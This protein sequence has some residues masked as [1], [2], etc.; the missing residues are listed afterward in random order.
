MD[1]ALE[2]DYSCRRHRDG[3]I[4]DQGGGLCARVGW[5]FDREGGKSLDEERVVRHGSTQE[6]EEG[7]HRVK[8]LA[9]QL[10]DSCGTV[11]VPH[12]W[13]RGRS[14]PRQGKSGRGAGPSGGT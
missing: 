7:P 14:F 8:A 9:L 5:S 1:E 4:K 6:Q 2:H 11:C 3:E 13:W 10:Q 12:V